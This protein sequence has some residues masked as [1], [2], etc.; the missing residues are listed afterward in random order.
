ME[1]T[2]SGLSAMNES[3][4]FHHTVHLDLKGAPPRVSYFA[5]IFPLFRQWGA[6][7]LLLEYEDM[8]P[9]QN[10]LK[11]LAAKHAY[12]KDDIQRIQQLAEQ[13][14]L[15][16]IPLVQT[17]GHFEF[18]L[19]HE[20][21]QKLREVAAY[22]TSLCPTHPDALDTV[23]LMIDQ[24]LT[25]HPRSHRF[26]IGADEVY[27]IGFCERCKKTMASENLTNQQ[28]FF[29]HIEKVVKYV[30][31]K[32]NHLTVLMWDDMMRFCELA[33]LKESKLGDIV[34]PMVWHYVTQFVLPNDI[35]DRYSKVFPNIWLASSFKGATS[36][37]AYLTNIMYHVDNHLAWLSVINQEKHKF[38]KICGIT[39]TGWQRFDHFAVLCELLPQALPSLAACLHVL[40]SGTF[41]SDIHLTVSKELEFEPTLPLIP[42]RTI[43]PKCKFPG[44]DIY[45][46]MLDF[47][48]YELDYNEY[49]HSDRRQ[50][51]MNDYN[52]QRGFLNPAH[53]QQLLDEALRLY[54]CFQQ[55]KFSI[56][57]SLMLVFYEDTVQEWLQTV[58]VKHLY[59]FLPELTYLPYPDTL[60]LFKCLWTH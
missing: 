45:L 39:V 58:V 44:S 2:L 42:D 10:D 35:W 55:L 25:L 3:S 17:F 53:L 7:S 36:S 51:W 32:Y 48:R 60:T 37:S 33:L 59:R 38:K 6:T 18:V 11:E 19:K 23:K 54:N 16:V 29:V 27:H 9:Y 49:I 28:M 52:L 30:K 47:L 24:I 34:E 46:Q 20:K 22:P 12:S 57:K 43:F 40:K 15:E 13:N 1:S 4:D 50:T 26:H 41:N 56:Q 8:F 31:C 14:N 5:E 21:F